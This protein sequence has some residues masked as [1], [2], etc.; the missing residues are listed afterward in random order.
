[1]TVTVSVY[2]FVFDEGFTLTLKKKKKENIYKT[3]VYFCEWDVSHL[4]WG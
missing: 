2:L 4:L 1:M 3:S